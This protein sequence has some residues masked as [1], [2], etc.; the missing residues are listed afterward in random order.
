MNAY[1]GLRLCRAGR[2]FI[3]FLSELLNQSGIDKGGWAKYNK[4]DLRASQGFD[5]GLAAGE[6]IRGSVR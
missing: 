3:V 2:I 1:R 5:R 6:A 4:S